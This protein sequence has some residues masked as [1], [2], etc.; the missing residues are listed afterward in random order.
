[1]KEGMSEESWQNAVNAFINRGPGI[2]LRLRGLPYEC[3]AKEV[4]SL[5]K[6][7]KLSH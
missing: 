6:K 1:M 5:T 2:I 3:T 4:V 7:K